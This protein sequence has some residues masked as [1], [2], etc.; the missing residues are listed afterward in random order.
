[1]AGVSPYI[2]ADIFTG[3]SLFSAQKI[4]FIHHKKKGGY[5]AGF[6]KDSRSL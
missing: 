4:K 5:Y 1:M 3:I 6:Q 2:A